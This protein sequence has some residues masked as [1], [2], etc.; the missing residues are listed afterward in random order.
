M[1]YKWH[2][3]RAA[4]SSVNSTNTAT[5]FLPI[6]SPGIFCSKGHQFVLPPLPPTPAEMVS[7]YEGNALRFQKQISTEKSQI[8]TTVEKTCALF[9]WR[10]KHFTRCAVLIFSLF[11]EGT[12]WPNNFSWHIHKRIA[13]TLPCNF[14]LKHGSN[15]KLNTKFMF[16]LWPIKHSTWHAIRATIYHRSTMY[17]NLTFLAHSLQC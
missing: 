15:D 3:L 17:C 12:M 8:N 11:K 14:L 13:I 6:E 2:A 4:M 7:L 9:A 16:P 10:M 5:W 1:L